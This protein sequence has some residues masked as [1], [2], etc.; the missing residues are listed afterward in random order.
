MCLSKRLLSGLKMFRNLLLII[1]TFII[2]FNAIAQGV[3]NGAISGSNET[4]STSALDAG[5]VKGSLGVNSNQ[6]ENKGILIDQARGTRITNNEDKKESIKDKNLP[7]EK[8]SKEPNNKSDNK[9][10][11]DMQQTNFQ[12]FAYQATGQNLPIY[13]V[14]LL[15]GQTF[16]SLQINTVP[17]EY[18]LGPGD[19]IYI[20]SYGG[21]LDIQAQY[22][23]NKE[24]E[25][26]IPKIGPIPLAGVTY[27]DAEQVITKSIEKVFKNF[28]ISVTMG[29]LKGVEIY[30]VGQA[31]DPGKKYV[32]NVATFY[33]TVL[34]LASP[35]LIG[36]MRNIQL[37][38]AGQTISKFDLYK[39]IANGDTESDLK[40]LDGDIIYIPPANDFVAVLGMV[41]SPAIYEI[42]EDEKINQ[43]LALSGGLPTLANNKKAQLER[44]DVNRTISR[45][46]EDLKLD[47]AGLDK[48]LTAGDIITV[49]PISQ[50]FENSITLSGNVSSPMRYKYHEN[51]HISDIL[52][53]A[54]QLI[55]GGYWTELNNGKTINNYKRFEANVDYA[56]I[57]RLD[58]INAI[59]KIISFNL[60]KAMKKES[61]DDLLLQPGDIIT[62]YKSDD[63][64]P[65]TEDSITIKGEPLGGLRRFAWR[66]N[67]TLKD[68]IPNA[69][70]LIDRYNYWQ[71]GIGNDLRN[72]I[73]WEYAQLIR[74]NDKNLQLDVQTFSLKDVIYSDDSSSKM[75]LMPG[76]Q[77]VIFTTKEQPLPTS[78]KRKY[79]TAKGEFNS[80]GIYQPLKNETIQHFINR[81][82]GLTEDA[83]LYGI[84]IDRESVRVSQQENINNLSEKIEAQLNADNQKKIQNT[85]VLADASSAAANIAFQQNLAQQR[86]E[87][88][89]KL[90]ATGRIALNLNPD[91]PVFPDLILDDGDVI[92]VPVK[93]AFVAAYGAVQN[94]NAII[95]RQ[96]M[97]V[98]DLIRLAGLTNYADTDNLFI[99]RADG[100][101]ESSTESNSFFSFSSFKSKQIYPGDT[102]VVT[103]RVDK[104]SGYT[105]FMSGLKDWTTIL[106]QFGLGIAAFKVLNL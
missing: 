39:F 65:E 11:V 33:N 101:L 72:D 97:Q 84:E 94:K 64:G 4:T 29:R 78:K 71:S 53:D 75:V 54:K 60:I 100:G 15:G 24:G 87:A 69:Q 76:D 79:V 62:V 34:G 23:I 66:N 83:Y 46:V 68:I 51:M 85:N 6:A 105:N 21:V 1:F 58:K 63:P 30:V 38:R 42:L 28:K 57:Q 41:N 99:F 74:R 2:N 44:V 103:D 20:N 73:N 9:S 96:G 8:K 19:Q 13:G 3:D 91:N 98:S 104:T 90:K 16:E 80:P 48:K 27:K 36:S 56:T 43:I 31:R 82:G 35:S 52:S 18:K 88:L 26:F 61:S 95:W 55:V 47:K 5:G 81:I 106:Y 14:N 59:T 67:L 10:Y 50:E 77:I 93:P 102:L 45:Q 12:K 7:E 40:L 22:T 25:I 92:S 49:F 32:N 37:K 70:W 86:L 89:R 17:N